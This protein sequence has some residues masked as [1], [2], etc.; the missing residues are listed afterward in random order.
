MSSLTKENLHILLLQGD[1]V[2]LEL[3]ERIPNFIKKMLLSVFFLK[4]LMF[5]Q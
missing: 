5:Y 2:G 1:G 4:K 3:M